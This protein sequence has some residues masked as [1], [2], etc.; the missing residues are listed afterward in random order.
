MPEWILFWSYRLL[1]LKTEEIEKE[2]KKL[3]LCTHKNCD[4]KVQQLPSVPQ[5]FSDECSQ[6][7]KRKQNAVTLLSYLRLLLVFEKELGLLAKPVLQLLLEAVKRENGSSKTDSLLDCKA[8]ALL[9]RTT[10][11]KL[12]GVLSANFISP[13]KQIIIKDLIEQASVLLCGQKTSLEG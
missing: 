10:Q 12:K 9:V 2:K 3:K 6:A 1:V 8:N 13:Q 4:S 11:E 7:K 5:K